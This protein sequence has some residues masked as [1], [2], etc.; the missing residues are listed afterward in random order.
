MINILEVVDL[1]DDTWLITF[2]FVLAFSFVVGMIWTYY[3]IVVKGDSKKK[4]EL[5]ENIIYNQTEDVMETYDKTIRENPKTPINN[6][7]INNY[8]K[9]Y[10]EEN[11][12]IIQKK[13]DNKNKSKYNNYKKTSV[14]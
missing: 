11:D 8:K 14:K 4:Q 2:Y 3:Q 7:Q 5:K 12:N 9:N 6:Y 1:Y 13:R 10:L